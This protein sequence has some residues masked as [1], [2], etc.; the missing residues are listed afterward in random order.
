MIHC[1]IFCNVSKAFFRSLRY[2][3][4][5]IALGSLIITIFK[6]I[7]LIIEYVDQKTKASQSN[8]AQCIIKCC[9]CCLCCLEKFLKYLNRNAYILI[10]IHG[11]NFW[12]GAKN[13][14]LL[15]VRNCA[16]VATLNWVGDFTLF[17][18][19]VFVS[20]GVTAFALWLFK[21][22]EKVQFF[23]VP[24]AIT[25]VM[26]YFATGAFTSIYEIAI[27]STFVCY[28]EDCE[29][30]DGLENKRYADDDLSKM[31][32]NKENPKSDDDQSP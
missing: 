21:R 20:A 30:N 25:F 27:D 10:A 11:Y 2:H 15:I 16:R 12:N 26:C 5:S 23:I 31:I 18:G 6:I 32:E 29:R 4:G 28:M 8:I 24:A 14:F 19:R 3:T 7:R 13:A 22:N 9:K 17:L 1:S